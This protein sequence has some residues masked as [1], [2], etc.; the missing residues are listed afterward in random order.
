MSALAKTKSTIIFVDCTYLQLKKE[1]KT[2]KD[3]E[4]G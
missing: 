3:S 1:I 4:L 2:F